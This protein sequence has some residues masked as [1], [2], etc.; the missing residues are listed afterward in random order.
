MFFS[1][2]YSGYEEDFNYK[3]EKEI[4]DVKYQE[5]NLS[6][7]SPKEIK[8]RLDNIYGKICKEIESKSFKTIRNYEE[9]QDR[10]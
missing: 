5:L 2:L 6:G 7:L 9:I 4:L 10:I 8:S 1:V 3:E